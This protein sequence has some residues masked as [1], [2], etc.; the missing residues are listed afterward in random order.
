VFHAIHDLAHPGT[1]TMRRL[2][3]GRFV[4]RCCASAHTERLGSMLRWR[5]A[6]CPDGQ[7]HAVYQ[8][9]LELFGTHAGFPPC[10][11]YCIPSAGQ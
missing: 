1:R 11:D 10:H 2:V 9:S 8:G 6:H 4:W 3:A 5:A 7:G